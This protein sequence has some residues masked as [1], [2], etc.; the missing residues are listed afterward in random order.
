[1]DK[2]GNVGKIY[3][4]V[5]LKGEQQPVLTTT[6]ALHLI[7]DPQHRTKACIYQFRELLEAKS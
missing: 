7:Y 3:M 2:W 5:F 4:D 6:S 1:M